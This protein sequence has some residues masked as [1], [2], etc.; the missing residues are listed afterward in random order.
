MSGFIPDEVVDRV[1]EQCD[2]LDIASN[3]VHLKK[4]G[5]YYFG[6]CPFHAER[7]ASFSVDPEKQ[8]FHCFGC[9]VGGDVFTLVMNLEGLTFVEAVRELA[10][11]AGIAIP[12]SE[13]VQPD[14]AA[15][16]RKNKMLDALT[17]AA[18]FYRY[19]LTESLYGKQARDYL[20]SRAFSPEVSKE[21]QLGFAPDAWDTILRFLRR[22]G[23][24]ADLLE[25]AG[26]VTARTNAPG[27]YDRFR[28]RV[29]FPIHDT[30]GRVIGFGG[31]V[32]GEGEPKYLNSPESPLFNKKYHL[33]N[34]HRAR[35]AI[36]QNQEVILFEGYVDVI[37]AW[38]AG[39]QNSV[40]SLG[41]ALT[42]DQARLLRRNTESVIICYDADRAGEKA[43][44]RG[45]DVL[46]NQGCSVKVAQMPADMDPDDYIRAYGGEAFRQNILTAAV[47]LTAFKLQQLHKGVDLN[48]EDQKLKLIQQALEVITDLPAAVERDH[49]MRQLAQNYNLSLEAIKV[50]QRQLYY[51]RKKKE[52]QGDKA[53]R[54]WNNR[55]I[56]KHM[57]AEQTLQPAFYNAERSL[58]ALMMHDP[59]VAERVKAEIGSAFN[60][61]DY[62]ALAAHVYAYYAEGNEADTGRFV[63]YLPDESLK[64]KASALAMTDFREEVN[65][66]EIA[67]YIRQVRTY[68][69]RLQ[70][71]EK[72]RQVQLAEQAG[73][74]IEA[75][76]IAQDIIRLEQ[77]VKYRKEGTLNG[78]RPE[79]ER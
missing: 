66:Q 70:I 4:K 42:D 24:E 35:K 58:I 49:Y 44:L 30:Q 48:D 6:L 26:L 14:S 12:T 37:A 56:P 5:R 18:R 36:R 65:E 60:V 10:D 15:V 79:H 9:G 23:F 7:T 78:K 13:E 34:I 75:A 72:K 64:K 59:R 47:P 68:P 25:E 57:V 50:Q 67:D 63:R 39:I 43:A 77:Q 21:F 46:K 53:E 11:Q 62:A 41:T 1:R 27:H 22:R 40:A 8:I 71:E 28:H 73:N 29:M 45:L 51:R 74:L 33:Y 20:I 69:L 16:Q 31:R 3:H 55:K 2:I 52:R 19:V 38:Q 32:I 61:D 76:K 17:L 54:E